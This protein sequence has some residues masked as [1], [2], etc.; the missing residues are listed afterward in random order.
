MKFVRFIIGLLLSLMF[1]CL[2]AVESPID[3][4]DLIIRFAGAACVFMLGI[5]AGVYVVNGEDE[6]DDRT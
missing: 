4:W 3:W 1:I 5:I 2:T 6:D